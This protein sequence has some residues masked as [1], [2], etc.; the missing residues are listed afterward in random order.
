MKKKITNRKDEIN[1]LHHFSEIFLDS[2]SRTADRMSC[3]HFL[4]PSSV[5][6]WSIKGKELK[7]YLR[8]GQDLLSPPIPFPSHTSFEAKKK[9]SLNRKITSHRMRCCIPCVVLWTTCTYSYREKRCLLA[10]GRQQFPQPLCTLL[11]EVEFN[12]L[13]FWSYH[14]PPQLSSSLFAAWLSAG[15]ILLASMEV[16]NPHR[17]RW[18]QHGRN[19][20]TP[21]SPKAFNGV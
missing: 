11:S 8:E 15:H 21:I 1:S 12:G 19:A 20:C 18:P 7:Q 6:R 14:G 9:D 2:C 17:K 16:S 5:R 13:H 10:A 3:S 4:F